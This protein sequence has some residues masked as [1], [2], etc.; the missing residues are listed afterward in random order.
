[1]PTP[2]AE[3]LIEERERRE[4]FAQMA[5]AYRRLAADP[6]AATAY[7]AEVA[8]WET[9]LADGLPDERWDEA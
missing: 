7:D 5:E 9:I 2:A 8:L 4:F 6:A 1:M 3:D